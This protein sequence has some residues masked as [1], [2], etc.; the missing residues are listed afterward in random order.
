MTLALSDEVKVSLSTRQIVNLLNNW[1]EFML[2]HS[3]RLSV[4]QFFKREVQFIV[5]R[6]HPLK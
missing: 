4:G 5:N 2:R 3:D 1:V 6:K